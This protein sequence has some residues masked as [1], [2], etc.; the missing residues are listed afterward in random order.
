M[1]PVTEH[2]VERFLFPARKPKRR[3]PEHWLAYCYIAA[4]VVAL[5][6]GGR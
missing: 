6:L 5:Y 2:M 1:M 3:G 4:V